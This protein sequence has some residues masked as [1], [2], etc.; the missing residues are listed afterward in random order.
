MYEI[1][2]T[3]CADCCKFAKLFSLREK[4]VFVYLQGQTALHLATAAGRQARL[5]IVHSMDELASR[6]DPEVN[7]DQFADS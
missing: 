6:Q 3:V 5:H 1:M 4:S 7:T 2:F